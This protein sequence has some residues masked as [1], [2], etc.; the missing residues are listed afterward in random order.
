MMTEEKSTLFLEQVGDELKKCVK[1][2]A[3]QS[4]CPIYSETKREKYVARGKIALTQAVSEGTLPYSDEFDSVLHNCLLCLSCVEVCSSNVRVDRIVTAARS[5]LVRERG[6]PWPKRVAFK[7]LR[8]GRWAQNLLFQSGSVVQ[9]LLFHRLPKTSGLRRRWPLPGVEKDQVVP[10][11]ARKSF[12]RR[13][14]EYIAAARESEPVVLFTGCSANYIYPRIAESALW[15]LHRFDRSVHIAGGQMCCGAPAES[16]GD[17]ETVHE[18]ARQNLTALASRFPQAPVIVLCSSG[19]YMFKRIY[20][21]LFTSGEEGR[22]AAALAHRTYDISEYLVDIIGLSALKAKATKLC[23][24]PTTYHDPCHLRRGQG[25]IDQPR[26]LLA[27]FCP[28]QYV[29]LPDADK[30][31]GMGGT[32]GLS[33][34][35]MSKAILGHKTEAIRLSNA[36]QIATGCPACMIQLQNGISRAG[37]NV[38]VKHTIEVVAKALGWEMPVDSEG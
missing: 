14:Q 8:A 15:T 36:R 9:T 26:T 5:S 4:V 35:E 6:M 30:C 10:R 18:L 33:H 16:H 22:L 20:P 37:L 12:R 11:L 21:E 3:C 1:C 27:A 2:G 7:V 17:Q 31:C 28:D 13:H 34:R 32:Y 38:E 23:T 19:G 29:P 24:T 25:V